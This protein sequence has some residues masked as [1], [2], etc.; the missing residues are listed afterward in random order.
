MPILLWP[1]IF[2]G[3]S[4]AST[5]LSVWASRAKRRHLR[6][7]VPFVNRKNLWLL[8]QAVAPLTSYNLA[9]TTNCWNN[10]ICRVARSRSRLKRLFPHF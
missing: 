1:A 3:L 7:A 6:I 4:V 9:S 10:S 2:I 8:R 5:W